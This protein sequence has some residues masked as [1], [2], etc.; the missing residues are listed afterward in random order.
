[1]ADTPDKP[2]LKAL[3][4]DKRDRTVRLSRTDTIYS[5]IV[6]RLRWVLPVTALAVVGILMIWP[7]VQLELA[8]RRFA[9]TTP[10]DK[11]ALEKA[12]TENKLL[13]ANYSSTD[14]KGRPF[15]LISTQATQQ[16]QTPDIV[17]L[18]TP[19]GSYTLGPDDII[20]VT[21][22][23][24]IYAQEKQLLD[25]VTNVVITRS[26]GG[27]MNTQ[28]LHVDL[29]NSNAHSD[30]PV[31]YAGPQGTLKAKAMD[32]SQGGQVMV[33]TGPATLTINSN[34]SIT[35]GGGL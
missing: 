26:D 22:N 23:E 34:T 30:E 21:A 14:S 8:D 1:M 10:M 7:K 6:A 31:T 2:R 29:K 35:P 17:L 20:K 16:N 12:A 33:F 9:P 18:E 5:A 11:A 15:S 13:N 28:K 27:V 19:K 24:G 3:G 4:D 25:L 32:I